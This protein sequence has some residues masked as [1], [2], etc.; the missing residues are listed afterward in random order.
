MRY[1]LMTSIICITLLEAWAIYNGINGA[2]L[3]AVVAAIAGIT[4]LMFKTPKILGGN[5]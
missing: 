5:K 2:I 4:G 1:V 3:T